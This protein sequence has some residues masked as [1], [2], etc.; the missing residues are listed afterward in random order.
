[1]DSMA[2]DPSA[3]RRAARQHRACLG[4]GSNVDPGLYLRRAI[5]RL[6]QIVLVEVTSTAWESRA[7]GSEGPNY[8][9]LAV[10]VTAPQTQEV[11]LRQLKE[12]EDGLGRIRTDGRKA[13][14][15]TIDIDLVIFDQDVLE[16]DLWTQAYRA[17]TVAELLPDLRCPDTDE[18]LAQVAARLAASISLKPRPEILTLSHGT[19]FSRTDANDPIRTRTS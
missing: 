1:M 19:D 3:S 11:L 6:R 5:G 14:L 4:L 13:D 17:V 12:I 16:A 7:V 15:L 8:V 2:P 9:N 18:P 10:L